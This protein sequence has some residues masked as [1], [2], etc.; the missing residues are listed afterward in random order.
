MNLFESAARCTTKKLTASYDDT[1][2]KVSKAKALNRRL[3]IFERGNTWPG[4]EPG[5]Q[6]SL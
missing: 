4:R 5:A 1:D 3:N 2:A 6:G